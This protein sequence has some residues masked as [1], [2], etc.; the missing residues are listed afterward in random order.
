[1]YIEMLLHFFFSTLKLIFYI[2]IPPAELIKEGDR[3]EDHSD[4]LCQNGELMTVPAAG[5]Q[6][7]RVTLQNEL[8]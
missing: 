8:R 5:F 1:M 4:K 3:G 6:A 2:P 7:K